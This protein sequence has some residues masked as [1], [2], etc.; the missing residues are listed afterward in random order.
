MITREEIHLVQR[1]RY[2]FFMTINNLCEE[3]VQK[4]KNTFLYQIDGYNAVYKKY[5]DRN[6]KI[7][8]SHRYDEVMIPE[9]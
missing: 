2:R 1:F 5:V 7:L 9:Q 6:I 4:N 3:A 8:Y